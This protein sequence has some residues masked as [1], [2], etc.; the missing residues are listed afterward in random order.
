M[1][2]TIILGAIALGVVVLIGIILVVV[3]LV[4]RKKKKEVNKQEK[5]KK[6]VK[7]GE[8]KIVYKGEEALFKIDKKVVPNIPEYKDLTKVDIRYDLIPPY[9]YAHIN[10][11]VENTELVYTIEEPVLSDKEKKVL[12]VLED[13]IKELINLSFINVKDSNTILVYLERNI[14]VLLTELSIKLTKESYVKIMYYI[15][16]DFV[17][18]NELEP[19]MNDYY[20]EDVECNGLNS[21]I[22]VVHRKFRNLRTNLEYKDLHKLGS[23]V[24]KLA[25]KCGKYVSYAEPLLDGSLPDGSRVNATYTTDVTSK[26]PSYTLRKFTKEPWS[27]IQLMQKGT[28]T[29]EILAF[30]W[31]LIEYEHSLLVIGATASGKTSLLNVLAFLFRH[32]LGLL[33]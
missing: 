18:L 13:G 16:R 25:Q 4:V 23:F 7:K 27:P 29:A 10:W 31:M 21:P 9:S 14:K 3:L 15:Y 12:D 33:Q 6:E 8:S 20:I 11:D 2:D 1:V 24:E 5:V 32:N 19:L 17:G 30:L 26:G 28:V 22:Y